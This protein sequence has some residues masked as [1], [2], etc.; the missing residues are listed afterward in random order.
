VKK[1]GSMR[2]RAFLFLVF[3]WFVWFM[4][5]TA[6][7]ILSPVLPLIEDEFLV[8]HAKA[9]SIFTVNGIG[10]TLSLFLS[11]TF[12]S[13]FGPRKSILSAIVVTGIALLLFP[14]VRTFEFYYVLAFVLGMSLGVYMPSVIPLI[15][16]YYEE[17]LWGK[18]IAIHGSAPSVS[19]FLTPF[20]ALAILAFFPW[21]AVFIVPGLVF[22][23]C[24]V[25]FYFVTD[26]VTLGKEKHYF[27]G[28]LFRQKA[29]WAMGIVWIFAAGANIGLYF[30]IPLY[31][32]K[33][34]SLDMDYANSIFGLSRLG[35]AILT[36]VA[37]FLVDRFSLKRACFVLVLATGIFTMLLALSN[38]R[39]MPIFL[40]LQACISPTVFPVGYVAVAKMFNQEQRGQA[41]GFVITIGMIGTGLV[42]YFLGLSGDYWSFR[43]G[44]FVLGIL[45]AL[46]SGLFYTLK[47]LE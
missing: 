13:L 5:F 35:G 17:R 45:T 41:T 14:L 15:T 25:I 24:A 20:I 23:L 22:L 8:S 3:I 19:V 32:V 47:E 10:Y 44:I 46:S 11:G 39:W 42:P 31:L 38:A 7:S 33:E 1:F 37:G 30:V 9:A 40:F 36:I 12:A 43:H 16:D 34:L 29:I 2:G 18:A 4:T 21:R 6:R 26:E 27:I 28:S